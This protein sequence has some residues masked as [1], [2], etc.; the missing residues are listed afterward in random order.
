VPVALP[1]ERDRLARLLVALGPQRAANHLRGMDED[2][3]RTILTDMATI[4]P[5]TAEEAKAIL[6]DF[7][8][9]LLLRRTSAGGVEYAKRV[10]AGLYGAD[11]AEQLAAEIDPRYSRPFLWL[12]DLPV[13][14]L[15]K[16]LNDEP[17]ATVALALAHIDSAI[18][19]QVLRHIDE[20]KRSDVA[21]R[22]ASLTSVAPDVVQAIDRS[23]RERLM[24]DLSAGIQPVEG[25]SILVEVLTQSSVKLQKTIV[26]S[27]RERDS[28]LAVEIQERLFV[29][30][31][32]V[33]LDDRAIQQVL[34]SIETMDLAFALKTA[35]EEIVDLITRNL[36][37][38]ARDSLL[39]EIDY[40]QSPKPAEVK[41]AKGRIVAA[42][43]ELEEAG[44]I[45]IDRPGAAMD[46]GDD[47]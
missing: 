40:L 26:E 43:R 31:D 10:L 13:V 36:S 27:I 11:R 7:T 2:K 30:D 35:S 22:M 21:M 1:A 5:M 28:K 20:P 45:E 12:K 32:I 46:D 6:V 3:V 37:E 47:D 29:F 34:K 9:E 17:P 41:S 18:S 23:L 44:T 14:D 4:P 19:A 25:V 42:I 8:R 16:A 39:E 33:M 38:R 15:G 24:S